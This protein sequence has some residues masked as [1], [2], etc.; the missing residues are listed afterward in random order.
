MKKFVAIVLMCSFNVALAD[1]NKWFEIFRDDD[2]YAY[3]V[4]KVP[5]NFTRNDQ[6]EVVAIVVGRIVIPENRNSKDTKKY[7]WYVSSTACANKQGD[8]V[9]LDMKGNF[10]GKNKFKFG[11]NAVGDYIAE[12]ICDVAETSKNE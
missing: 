9:Y 10:I 6:G 12:F 5:I 11:G 3:E 1:T 7:K 2:N 4:E 8:F